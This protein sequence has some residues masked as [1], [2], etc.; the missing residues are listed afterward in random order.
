MVRAHVGILV[1]GLGVSCPRF[2]LSA[3]VDTLIHPGGT[4]EV[5]SKD[6]CFDPVSDVAWRAGCQIC[7]WLLWQTKIYAV[8]HLAN[9][10]QQEIL[11]QSHLLLESF[12]GGHRVTWPGGV[13]AVSEW[14]GKKS[15]EGKRHF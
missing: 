12:H 4:A 2:Y 1:H 3:F 6:G 10:C 5:L 9:E 15:T 11:W 13:C 8:Y 14:A 7:D